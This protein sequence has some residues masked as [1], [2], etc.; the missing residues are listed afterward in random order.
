MRKRKLQQ[1]TLNMHACEI[2]AQ[3][4]GRRVSLSLAISVGRHFLLRSTCISSS[5]FGHT[6]LPL[7]ASLHSKKRHS[8]RRSSLR[9]RSKG[10]RYTCRI[11]ISRNFRACAYG[12]CAP[13][14]TYIY[15]YTRIVPVIPLGWLALA[16][17]LFIHTMCTISPVLH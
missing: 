4:R 13:A 10:K 14:E 15:I 1:S 3:R 12:R 6:R 8:C 9:F 5:A 7:F 16:R 2:L 17:Q 11:G